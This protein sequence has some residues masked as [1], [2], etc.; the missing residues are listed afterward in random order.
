MTVV[1]LWVKQLRLHQWSK[2]ALLFVPVLA[3]FQFL[4]LSHVNLWKL[5]FAFLSF[6]LAASSVYIF[7]DI[8]DVEHDRV[9]PVKRFR[10]IASKRIS[11]RS[12]IFA[13]IASL[14]IA[15]YLGVQ[16]GEL[17]LATLVMYLIGTFAYSLWLKKLALIDCITL[18]GLYTIRVIAG[19]VASS[20][21]ISF[22]LLAFSAFFFLSLAWLKRYAEL[23][24]SQRSGSTTASGRGYLVTDLPL[25]LNFGVASALIA[26]LIF[27]LYLDSAAIRTQYALPEIGWL[28]IPFL[29]YLVGRMWFKAFRGQM[30]EDP[31]LFLFRDLPSLLTVFLM[32]LALVVAHV[33][34]VR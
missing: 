9:H 3:S 14:L 13:A 26:V 32:S 19:G 21:S 4:S 10:P 30:N 6:S 12:G 29:T 11:I 20:I 33:G 23:D 2:N 24:A 34:L 16:T 17:F 8:F 31:V 18:A 15:L 5:F 28:A 27:S 25:V 1:K 22:W 7:N